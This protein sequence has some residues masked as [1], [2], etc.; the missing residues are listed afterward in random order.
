MAEALDREILME[1]FVAQDSIMSHVLI[2]IDEY[3]H[4]SLSKTISLQNHIHI[5]YPTYSN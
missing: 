4:T 3:T 5:Q 2:L 1:G